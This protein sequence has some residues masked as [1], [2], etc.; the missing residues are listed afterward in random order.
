[1]RS[2]ECAWCKW[3]YRPI[4][5]PPFW[6]FAFPRPL[7]GELQQKKRPPMTSSQPKLY[8]PSDINTQMNLVPFCF[9]ADW[10]MMGST[11]N[12]CHFAKVY[13]FRG[14]FFHLFMGKKNQNSG[15]SAHFEKTNTALECKSYY[16]RWMWRCDRVD[17]LKISLCMH[18]FIWD[19]TFEREGH[20][21][22]LEHWHSQKSL[23]N[24]WQRFSCLLDKSIE[25]KCKKFFF[26]RWP[27]F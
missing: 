16:C 24:I 20:S 11:A 7:S 9:R 10:A 18:L 26:S 12:F 17:F 2:C 14:C 21:G 15:V 5:L 22:F 19:C 13:Y 8:I 25:K 27:F 23:C 3:T 1:M 6:S 4:P